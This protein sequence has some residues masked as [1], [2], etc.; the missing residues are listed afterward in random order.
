MMYTQQ[1]LAILEHIRNVI[2][3]APYNEHYLTIRIMPLDGDNSHLI[4]TLLL[5]PKPIYSV[6]QQLYNLIDE[7]NKDTTTD[8]QALILTNIENGIVS[9]YECCETTQ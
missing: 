4:T 9:L 5:A 7:I 1:E 2:T 3:N 6:K 8:Q